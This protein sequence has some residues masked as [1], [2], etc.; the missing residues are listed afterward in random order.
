MRRKHLYSETRSL[1]CKPS[2]SDSKRKIK[3]GMVVMPLIPVQ[4]QV[5]FWEFE[6]SL[7]YIV[8]FRAVRPCQRRRER[9]DSKLINV[10][11]FK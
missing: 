4:R 2:T 5:D 9:K 7:V 6:P 1:H 3:L 8:S 10:S 11:N